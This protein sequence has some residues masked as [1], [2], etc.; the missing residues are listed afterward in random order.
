MVGGSPGLRME[1]EAGSLDSSPRAV[2]DIESYRQ[3]GRGVIRL[4]FSKPALL[5]LC[6]MVVH[7]EAGRPEGRLSSCPGERRVASMWAGRRGQGRRVRLVRNLGSRIT[8]VTVGSGRV[9]GAPESLVWPH[10][11]W[12]PLGGGVC[13]E[14]S[15]N[16][17]R[18]CLWQSEALIY[19]FK[20]RCW[21]VQGSGGQSACT[22]DLDFNFF[23]KYYTAL[24]LCLVL[25]KY[26]VPQSSHNSTW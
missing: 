26:S 1:G 22:A 11:R 24:S 7:E 13:E 20:G 25:Y 21:S 19:L 2:G 16:P 8:V 18:P 4:H 23:N 15:L 14:R 6:S 9:T 17:V 12:R 5:S 3:Q 10:G